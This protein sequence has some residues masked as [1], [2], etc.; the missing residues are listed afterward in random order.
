MLGEHGIITSG[1][2]TCQ[3]PLALVIFEA[4]SLLSMLAAGAEEVS[5]AARVV[6]MVVAMFVAIYGQGIVDIGV[7][8]QLCTFTSGAAPAPVGTEAGKTLSMSAASARDVTPSIKPGKQLS[9]VSVI[10]MICLVVAF[11]I[12]PLG[13]EDSKPVSTGFPEVC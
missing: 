5:A 4:A 2:T 7:C 8:A 13:T 6:D 1:G 12:S 3:S 11:G 10:C 9:S